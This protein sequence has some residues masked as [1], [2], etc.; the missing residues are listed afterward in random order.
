MLEGEDPMGRAA[1]EF[2]A[3]EKTLELGLRTRLMGIVNLTP[4]S[5]S[6]GGRYQDA[7]AA[8]DY[9]LQL[10]EQGIDIL[11][12]GG[13]SSRPGSSPI[14]AQ[15]ERDRVLPVLESIRPKTS[16]MISVDTWKAPV[17]RQALEAGADIIND[18][19]ALRFDPGR[20]EV[21]ACFQAGVVLMHMRGTPKTMQVIPPSP[22]I[23]SEVVKDL[24]VSVNQAHEW[25]IPRGRILL[26]PGIGFGK[27]VK[28]NLVLMNRL[29]EL[30]RLNLPIL[31]G[32]SRK[33][34]IGAIL[35]RPVDDRVLGTAGACACCMMR[36]AHVL[37]VHDVE[38]IRQVTDVV[39]AILA[40]EPWTVINA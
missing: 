8:S 34:W 11:D 5:F 39:D 29:P 19:S 35:D 3:R 7:S 27:T 21:V 33:G 14:S 30:A 10:V 6:D 18:I 32:P 9:S 15:E 38:E 16:V 1:F 13:E 20:A 31:V 4:D 12:L 22:D 2:R 25:H 26:D 17:A 24:Q 36:G 37:R 28:D 40:E 23:L